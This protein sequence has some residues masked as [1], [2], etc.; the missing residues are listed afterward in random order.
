MLRSVHCVVIAGLALAGLAAQPAVAGQTTPS[1]APPA[2]QPGASATTTPLTLRAALDLAR[3][4]SQ[5]F[6]SAQIAAL[7]ATEDRK[8]A[9]AALLPAL[10]EFSQFI[11]TEPN[12]TPSGI[13]V[14]NDGPQVYN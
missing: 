14:S 9:R 10:S 13:W 1:P 3:A 4:N 12:G 7:L 11:G 6:R 2:T 5:Q 8:Q